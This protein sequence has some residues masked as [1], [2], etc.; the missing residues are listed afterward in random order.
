MS[1]QEEAINPLERSFELS[2]SRQKI[3][4]EVE[5]RLRRLAP[6][7][8]LQGFRPGKVPLKVVAQ[9]HGA[10]LRQEILSEFLQKEFTDF[11]KKENFRV[12]GYPRF[13]AINQEGNGSD[14]AFSVTFEIYPDF[15]LI[16]F[17]EITVKKPVLTIGDTEIQKTLE[18][19]RKQQAKFE[20]VDRTAKMG[21]RVN[22]DYNGQLN[23]ENFAGGQASGYSF[24]L[25]EGHLLKDFEN[26]IVGLRA[27]EE[28]SFDLAFPDNYPGKEVAGK[29][30][31]FTVKL[32]QV[33]APVLPEVDGAFAKSLG[34]TDGD[35]DK[36]RQEIKANL[37]RE[38]QQR[39][40]IRLKEQVMQALLDKIDL[41][42][43]RALVQREMENLL[44]EFRKELFSQKTGKQSTDIPREVFLDRAERRVKLGL[45]IAK[46]ID[47]HQLSVK[48]EQLKQY[49]ETFA[50]SYENPEQVV[51]W[52]YASPERIKKFEPIVLEDNVV[53]WILEKARVIEEATSFEELMERA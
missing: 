15:E 49:I 16:D 52:H 40:R 35:L 9:Q 46:L 12:A 21:D 8:K 1:T 24:V 26:A 38:I 14:Y 20:T 39:I 30:A 17:G 18:I 28:K 42:A 10:Q 34:I 45:I 22:I 44:E 7:V 48:P 11:V 31:T 53:S 41:T 37:H 5:N 43:P 29:K 13:S 33:E 47:T 4:A 3:E 23:G 32:N 25:G 36:M 50:Q 27:G 51:A 19:L 2:V 6:K